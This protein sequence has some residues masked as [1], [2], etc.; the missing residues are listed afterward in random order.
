[1]AGAAHT[2]P[3][4]PA[5]HPAVLRRWRWS[6]DVCPAGVRCCNFNI[7]QC[8]GVLLMISDM[9][10]AQTTFVSGQLAP[11]RGSATDTPNWL[12]GRLAALVANAVVRVSRRKVECLA[13]ADPFGTEYPFLS[14]SWPHE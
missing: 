14:N 4:N 3:R 5:G 8:R 6:G 12:R 9:P 2:G 11:V 10:P 7:I 13:D 1:M